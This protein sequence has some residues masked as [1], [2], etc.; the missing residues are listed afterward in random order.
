MVMDRTSLYRAIAPLE[1]AG[2]I[3]VHNASSGRSK[4]ARLTENG[5]ETLDEANIFW[6]AAQS[7][8]IQAFGASRW[9]ALRQEL[10]ALT[11]VSVGLRTSPNI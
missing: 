3:E 4:L 10:L 1:R 8:L 6:D 5:A 2:W 7:D 9:D 11:A